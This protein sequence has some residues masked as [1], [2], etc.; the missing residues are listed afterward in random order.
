MV[1]KLIVKCTRKVK[2]LKTG[3]PLL[4]SQTCDVLGQNYYTNKNANVCNSDVDCTF[5]FYCFQ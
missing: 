5:S 3:A 1:Q 2:S 4:R